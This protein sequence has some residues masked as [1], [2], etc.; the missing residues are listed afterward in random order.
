MQIL[1]IQIS[2][3][4]NQMPNSFFAQR[5]LCIVPPARNPSF[6]VQ[7]MLVSLGAES[8]K[9]IIKEVNTNTGLD[10]VPSKLLVVFY[11]FI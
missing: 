5:C 8:L 4:E 10:V 3:L 2:N 9:F 11:F 1:A 6:D 7:P